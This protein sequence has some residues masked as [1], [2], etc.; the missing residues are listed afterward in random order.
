MVPR[1]RLARS[2]NGAT[3]L[4]VRRAARS[5][6]L[7][8]NH[9]P[10]SRRTSIPDHPLSRPSVRIAQLGLNRAQTNVLELIQPKFR[11]RRR[12]RRTRARAQQ[13][14]VRRER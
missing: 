14:H 9:R 2:R 12:Q 10:F 11:D 1:A 7:P 13:L 6:F 5:R 4:A 8:F 3:R